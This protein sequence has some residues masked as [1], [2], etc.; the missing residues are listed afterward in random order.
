[1]RVEGTDDV[2][3]ETIMPRDVALRELRIMIETKARKRMGS[4]QEIIE[5]LGSLGLEG[6]GSGVWGLGF[7][8][9]VVSF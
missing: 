4:L 1:M 3:A 2:A 5:G 9:K 7:K 6:L 8:A